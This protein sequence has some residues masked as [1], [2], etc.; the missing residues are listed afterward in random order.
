MREGG[1]G[2]GGGQ[3]MN[4]II[5]YSKNHSHITMSPGFSHVILDTSIIYDMI[6]AVLYAF[7]FFFNYIPLPT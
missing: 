1:R 7:A 2:E 5:N 3:C 4:E 6:L